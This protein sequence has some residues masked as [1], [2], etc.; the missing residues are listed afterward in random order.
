MLADKS[1]FDVYLCLVDSS[2]ICLLYYLISLLSFSSAII[3][4]SKMNALKSIPVSSGASFMSGWTISSSMIFF[5]FSVLSWSF[6]FKLTLYKIF[7]K[8]YKF[9]KGLLHF[10]RLILV[11]FFN[12]FQEVLLGFLFGCIF[13]VFVRKDHHFLFYFVGVFFLVITHLLKLLLMKEK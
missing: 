13:L 9:L 7:Y 5:I 12:V 3:T 6:F 1:C 10:F 11:D 8:T 4:L 2:P